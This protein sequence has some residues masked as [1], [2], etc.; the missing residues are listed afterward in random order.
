[1]KTLREIINEV[2]KVLDE[3]MKKEVIPTGGW[4][5]GYDTVRGEPILRL[6]RLLT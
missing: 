2:N 4:G 1:M 5:Y 3:N 6:V